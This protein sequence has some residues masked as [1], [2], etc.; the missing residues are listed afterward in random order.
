MKYAKKQKV[1][2]LRLCHHSTKEGGGGHEKK[3]FHQRFLRKGTGSY[4][5]A[6]KSLP[7]VDTGGGEQKKR[8]GPYGRPGVEN[9]SANSMGGAR[10]DRWRRGELHSHRGTPRQQRKSTQK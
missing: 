3:D 8:A 2:A 6:K 1:D 9:R 4:K 7:N 10:D 5:K